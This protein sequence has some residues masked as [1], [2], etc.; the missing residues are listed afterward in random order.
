M[1]NVIMPTV[2]IANVIIANVIMANTTMA[3]ETEPSVYILR[4]ASTR[5]VPGIKTTST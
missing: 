5:S 4:S 2:I 1:A 3:N